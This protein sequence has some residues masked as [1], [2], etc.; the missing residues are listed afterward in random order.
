MG[1]SRFS[2]PTKCGT[3]IFLAFLDIFI[4]YVTRLSHV[5][6]PVQ[7][8]EVGNILWD[9]ILVQE[10]DTLYYRG[11]WPFVGHSISVKAWLPIIWETGGVTLFGFTTTDALHRIDRNIPI[12]TLKKYD[13][14]RRECFLFYRKSPN[15]AEIFIFENVPQDV[16]KF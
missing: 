5:W 14:L 6:V 12:F 8:E 1:K 10:C 9:V 13:S 11:L 2:C 3:P 7:H 15:I 4:H 16:E